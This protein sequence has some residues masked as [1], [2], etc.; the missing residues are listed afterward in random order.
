MNH[1][2]ERRQP[3]P[4]NMVTQQG[5]MIELQG[6]YEHILPL[7]KGPHV[8]LVVQAVIEGNDQGRIWADESETPRTVF[9]WDKAHCYYLVGNT[10]NHT[11][12]RAL[13][14]VITEEIEPEA[15]EH[16]FLDFKVCCTDNWDAKI[17]SIF[18]DASLV[19]KERRFYTFK[20]SKVDWK[21]TI[22][23]GFTVKCIDEPLLKRAFRNTDAVTEEIESM[24]NSVN[25]FF[26]HGFGFCAV[27]NN[28]IACWCTA[29]HVSKYRCGIGIETV[30][31]Y[32]RR[33]V[34]TATAAAFVDHCITR[35]I[36]PCWDCW[37]N[38]IPSITVAEKVGFERMLNYSVY[39]GSFD[40]FGSLCIQGEY[41]YE[42]K[43]YRK[44]AELLE[45]A[46]TM[47][48]SSRLYYFTGCTWALAG[49]NDN[50]LKNLEKA[51]NTGFT[52]IERLERDTRLVKLHKFKKWST[53]VE[54][55]YEHT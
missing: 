13:E 2:P 47:K 29:E 48:A 39:F 20:K 41:Y 8:S 55:L 10:G 15:I 40:E 31:K 24:W 54:R 36:V 52:D 26:K 9:M 53:L 37:D 18:K 25:D 19:K 23:P 45:K 35:S 42:Q 3:N 21:N 43:K 50:A 34:A 33:G 27:Y 30:E 17:H 14:T 11:F 5:I 6:T 7:F 12:N 4:F 46:L 1:Y 51:V 22:P 38:N 44:A 16:N 32:Q 28:E 49:E